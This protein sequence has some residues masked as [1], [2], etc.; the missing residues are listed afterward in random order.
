MLGRL[1]VT[2]AGCG[3]LIFAASGPAAAGQP[4]PV[5]AYVAN[6]SSD[7]VTPIDT[8]TNTALAQITV[9]NGPAAI[10]ITPNG[11]TA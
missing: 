1:S 9:G 6:A 5:T 10:A 3:L 11:K 7:T 4:D 2:L 8:A